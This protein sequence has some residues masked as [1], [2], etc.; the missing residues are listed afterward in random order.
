MILTKLE[1]F[2]KKHAGRTFTILVNNNL[3]NAFPDN[4]TITPI[5]CRYNQ[6]YKTFELGYLKSIQNKLQL[7]TS[8]DCID[9]LEKD[10][11]NTVYGGINLKDLL[12]LDTTIYLHPDLESNVIHLTSSYYMLVKKIACKYTG[13]PTPLRVG[14]KQLTSSDF[15]NI[16]DDFLIHAMSSFYNV[17]VIFL[18]RKIRDDKTLRFYLT[19]GSFIPTFIKGDQN[20]FL[21]N[22]LI[23]IPYL[24]NEIKDSKLY[25]DSSKHSYQ[26]RGFTINLLT[27]EEICRTFGL[28]KYIRFTPTIK[29]PNPSGILFLP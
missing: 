4:A 2:T 20:S 22:P 23:D 26:F 25:V 28:N 24:F 29:R 8:E 1:D 19:L 21:F 7:V 12:H 9:I 14:E 27:S 3:T 16:Y 17:L 11:Y 6:K 15:K 13:S 18:L 5:R 10:L